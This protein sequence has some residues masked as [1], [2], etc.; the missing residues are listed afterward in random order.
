MRK[1]QQANRLRELGDSPRKLLYKLLP[2]RIGQMLEAPTVRHLRTASG[3]LGTFALLG[4]CVP[5]QA[6]NFVGLAAAATMGLIYQRNRPEPVKDELGNVGAV[7]KPSP[8]EMLAAIG[9]TATGVLVS[10]VLASSLGFLLGV[11]FEAIFCLTSCSAL[12]LVSL[13][14]KVY[15]CFDA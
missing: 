8:K 2:A 14:V 5:S 1:Q 10:V 4:L 13:F 7:Q 9:A 6:S 3:L 15:Q 11:P 12:W